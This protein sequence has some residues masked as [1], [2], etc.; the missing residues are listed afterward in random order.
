MSKETPKTTLDRSLIKAPINRRISR[1]RAIL[2]KNSATT[3]PRLIS[4]NG[5][6]Q[7]RIDFAMAD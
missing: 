6:K 4:K 1:G 5:T 3:M 2:K 7:T